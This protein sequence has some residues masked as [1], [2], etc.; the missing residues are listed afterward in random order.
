[1]SY[2][3]T[4]EI[5]KKYADVLIKFALNSG[6]GIRRD[7]V[8]FLQLSESAKPMAQHLMLS[9]LER[10]AHPIIHYFPEELDRFFFEN[11]SMKQICYFPKKMML[12]RVADADHFV[13]IVSES[14][15][16]ELEGVDSRKILARNKAAKF[17][18][19]AR[20][21][22]EYE[23]KMTWT[24]GL[25]GTEAEAIE[26][27]MSLKQYWNQIIKA[28]F[29]DFKNPIVK[30]KKVVSRQKIILNKLNTLKIKELRVKG[31]DVDLKIK[32]GEKRKW[33]GGDGRNI[34][35]FELFTSPDWRGTEGWVRFNQPLYR[36]G[37]LISGVELEFKK[38][39]VVKSKAVKN[40]KL[41]RDMI[42]VENADKIGEFSLTDKRFSRI[43]KF[44]AETLYDENVGGRYGNF[45]IALGAAYKDCFK[46]SPKNVKKRTWLKLGYNIDCAV[47]TDIMSTSDRIVTATLESGRERV[48]YKGGRFQI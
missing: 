48:I 5:L 28:C 32:L 17:Y 2:K 7:E 6:K 22:K 3:P 19:D 33:V 9:V 11:A 23:G 37:T 16:H 45:H 40:E 29:L 21:K 35:S 10:G 44:M 41:L 4:E 12:A 46:G 24:V 30:W 34:P 20:N 42:K 25:Y 39:V 8:V 36:Y 15:K 27:G 31:E 26:A 38:G 43:T 13:A 18:I 47:H 14:D 1:M